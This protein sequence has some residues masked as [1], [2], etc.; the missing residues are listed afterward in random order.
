MKEFYDMIFKRKT[1][2]KFD[3]ALVLTEGEKEDVNQQIP[4]LI[5]LAP[6]IRVK[7][8]IVKR[9]A[10]TA[11]RGDYCLLLYSEKKPFYLL[12]AGYMLEQ[13]DLFCEARDLGVCWYGL[14]KPK[15]TQLD[16]LD[17]VIMLSFGKSREQDFRKSISD[18]KRK[19][20]GD[21]WCGDFD[22]DVI[23]AVRLAPSA[24]NTQPWKI[25]SDSSVI[26]VYRNT[27]IKSFIPAGKL[28]Y[29]N[30]IDMGICLCFL[31]IAMM[32]K[33]YEFDRTLICDEDSINELL[34]TAAYEYKT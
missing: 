4:K 28:P 2:R 27:A 10:T 34:K 14:A 20:R 12:N 8:E 24:C 29:Y 33:G 9:V 7:L 16:G 25:N 31:E 6:E 23:E 15:E 18:F 11:K 22:P 3:E 30:S 5:P 1:I 13:M 17:Y 26:N 32:Q 21:I 19:P